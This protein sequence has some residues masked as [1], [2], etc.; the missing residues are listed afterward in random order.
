MNEK[1]WSED[2]AALD[3]TMDDIVRASAASKNTDKLTLRLYYDR[4]IIGTS[5]PLR[6]YAEMATYESLDQLGFNLTREV[7]DASVAM[8]CRPLHAKVEPNDADAELTMACKQLGR[9]LDGVMD[10]GEF[11]AVARSAWL[12]ACLSAAGWVRWYVDPEGEIKCERVDPLSVYWDAAEGDDPANLYIETGLPRHGL[13]ARYPKHRQ[14]IIDAAE[15]VMPTVVGVEAAGSRRAGNVRVREAWCVAR[16]GQP[17]RHVVRVGGVNIVD[18]PWDHECHALVRFRYTRE[19]RSAGGVSLARMVAPYH[20]WTNRIIRQI[21]DAARGANPRLLAHEDSLVDQVSDIPYE[22]IKWAGTSPP[23]LE[24]PRTISDQL[25]SLIATLRERAY[26]EA[27]VNPSAASGN[28]P[29]GLN[30]APAQREWIDIVSARAQE[31]QRQWERSYRDSARV[32]CALAS[33]AYKSRSV[34][35][36]APGTR[37]IESIKFPSLREQKYRIRYSLASGLSQTVSGRLEQIEALKGMGMVDTADAAR[38]LELPDVQRLADRANAPRDLAEAQVS[39]ALEKGVV[40]VPSSVQ[41][42]GPLLTIAS[43]EY[44][45]ALLSE[46]MH[47]A[48]NVEALRRL[49]KIAQARQ[50]AAAPPSAPAPPPMPPGPPPP[51]PPPPGNPMPGA[52]P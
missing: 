48:E 34:A 10:A 44:Q 43:Q 35:V 36:R 20:R 12:D 25:I 3:A 29:A 2:V 32:V 18:E 22:V 15:H 51:M 13:A 4:P 16:H 21:S 50:D 27:G 33:T 14:A 42:V 1:A 38:A 8:I 7:V 40:S 41:D 39:L 30:S 17:G 31:Q 45:R 11:D 19:F 23:T 49:I 52:M 9:L 37:L 5:D 47:P 6:P 28:R 26:A 46:E 24:A